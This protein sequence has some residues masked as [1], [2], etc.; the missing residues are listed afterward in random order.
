MKKYKTQL[1]IVFILAFL[2][3][4]LNALNIFTNV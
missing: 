3:V 4:V 2:V 1:T